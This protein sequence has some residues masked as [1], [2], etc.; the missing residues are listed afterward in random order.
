MVITLLGKD[1]GSY[2]KIFKKFSLKTVTLLGL[3]LV[4]LLEKIHGNYVL[5]RDLKPENILMGKGNDSN[6]VFIVDFG[7]SK[8]FRD[9]RGKHIP[10]KDKKSFIGTTRYASINAH[11][12]IELS[13]K[14]DLESLGYVLI[15]FF[16]GKFLLFN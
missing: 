9:N 4:N 3:Q 12:G 14:D 1:L 7:I 15:Y 10:F 11:Q 2:L 5:H 16:K 6:T 8:F 13:R